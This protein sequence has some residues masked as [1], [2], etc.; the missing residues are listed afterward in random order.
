[1]FCL[2]SYFRTNTPFHK[3]IP[4]QHHTQVP[5]GDFSRFLRKERSGGLTNRKKVYHKIRQDDVYLPP[6]REAGDTVTVTLTNEDCFV[7]ADFE[8]DTKGCRTFGSN[9]GR[10]IVDNCCYVT[11]YG[12]S[13]AHA[14]QINDGQL[15]SGEVTFLLNDGKTD[16]TQHWYQTCGSK[17][18]PYNFVRAGQKMRAGD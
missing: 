18:P 10:V 17:P 16:G 7:A 15:T 11:V 9:P 12:A 14:V 2:R 6:H 1:M 3:V 5:F 8:T 4:E 13:S